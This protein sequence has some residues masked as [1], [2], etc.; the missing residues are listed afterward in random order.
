M[1][2]VPGHTQVGE[3][4]AWRLM[5]EH[6]FATLISVGSGEPH[7]TL[8]PVVVDEGNRVLRGHVAAANPH[9]KLIDGVTPMTVLF[10][11]PHAYI[12]PEWYDHAEVP[13]WNYL[14]AEAQGI[15]EPADRETSLSIVREL[16]SLFESPDA[17]HRAP[18]AEHERILPGIVAFVMPIHRVTTKAKV[19]RNKSV[20]SREGV[21][22]GLKARA[23]ADDLALAR[24]MEQLS[25]DN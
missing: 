4:L 25:F 6:P 17:V 13:T 10:Y 12:S 21:V 3:E 15:P 2:Y 1:I 14:L 7:V 11:G 24:W 8:M 20:A 16:V 9:A 22:S 18:D 23:T 19:S 5:A